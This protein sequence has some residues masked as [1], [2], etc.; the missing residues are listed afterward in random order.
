[1]DED[2]RYNLA[3]LKEQ[4][5][6]DPGVV[7]FVGAGISVPVG[8]PGWTAFLMAQAKRVNREPE[9]T[10]FLQAGQYEDAAEF[11]LGAQG[12]SDFDDAISKTFGRA[13]LA[14]REINGAA[15]LLSQIGRGPFVTTNFDRVLETCFEQANKPFEERVWGARSSMITRAIQENRRF[16]LKIH[17]DVEDSHD[18]VLTRVEYDKNYGPAVGASGDFPLRRALRHICESRSILFVG[19]SL[20]ADR[21]MAVLWEVAQRNPYLRHYAIVES[22]P[23]DEAFGRQRKF[24]SDRGVRPIWYPTGQHAEVVRLLQELTKHRPPTPVPPPFEDRSP[25]KIYLSCSWQLHGLT[26]T[27][28]EAVR[29]AGH[30]PL[31]DE[32][33]RHDAVELSKPAVTALRESR[34]LLTVLTQKSLSHSQVRAELERADSLFV[35]ICAISEHAAHQNLPWFVRATTTL[36]HYDTSRIVDETESVLASLHPQKMPE[37]EAMAVAREQMVSIFR[38]WKRDQA[39]SPN[40]DWQIDLAHQVVESAAHELATLNKQRFEAHIGRGHNFLMRAKP[41]FEHATRVLA[42]SIDT[43]S[44]FWL[45]HDRTDQQIARHY[46]RA[47]PRSTQRLFVFA[48]PES[49]HNYATILNIHARRYGDTGRVYLCSADAYES[50]A[51][52]AGLNDPSYS[53]TYDFAVLDYPSSNGQ[54]TYVATL[55]G[56]SFK[57]IREPDHLHRMDEFKAGMLKLGQL[58]PSCIDEESRI[59]RWQVDFQNDPETWAQRLRTLFG[60]RRL[61]VF[62][63][64]FVAK[65]ALEADGVKQDLQGLLRELRNTLA[66]FEELHRHRI[67]LKDF[68]IGDAHN[69]AARDGQFDGRIRNDEASHYPLML[70]MRFEDEDGLLRWYGDKEHSKL[71]RK[72]YELLDARVK[73]LFDTITNGPA[74]TAYEHI[75][76]TIA[77]ALTRR[78]YREADTIEDVVRRRP[79]RPPIKFE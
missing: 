23:T 8:H 25:L 41:V 36:D 56:E 61:D 32:E 62:H 74:A 57:V 19:C 5:Q 28:R 49:A 14:G 59:M 17:G 68:W 52:S 3:L 22:P 26:E 54:V 18:R 72:L 67:R 16:L 15:K 43:V 20:G 55:D 53:V 76:T 24:L 2:S 6:T 40:R 12:P 29:S 42:V 66:D 27:I 7:P 46:W 9:V 33:W 47:Q 79:F 21:T 31:L 69:S 48:S 63:M 34:V 71:R 45:S 51:R 65:T 39:P 64:V 44:Q 1:M 10:R 58:E 78:D 37:Y 70:M 73:P 77:S 13:V 4:L 75:E 38:L 35:K 11:L 50:F 30:T 60:A